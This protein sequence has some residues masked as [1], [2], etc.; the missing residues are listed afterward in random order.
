MNLKQEIAV[1]KTESLELKIINAQNVNFFDSEFDIV[2]HDI[3]KLK[4]ALNAG[5]MQDIKDAL[6]K[7]A[8]PII[9]KLVSIGDTDE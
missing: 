9:L 3:E 2:K 5:D 4:L 1:L 8:L 7:T 6:F